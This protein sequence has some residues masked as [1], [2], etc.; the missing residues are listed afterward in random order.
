MALAF[1]MRGGQRPLLENQESAVSKG[2]KNGEQTVSGG[3]KCSVKIVIGDW[4]RV[5]CIM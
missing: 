3:L 2:W 4:E 5:A 1:E